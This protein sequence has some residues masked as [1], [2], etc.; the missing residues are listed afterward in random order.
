M[1]GFS[2]ELKRIDTSVLSREGVLSKINSKRI[3]ND[4]D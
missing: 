2:E 4:P 3:L 1:K